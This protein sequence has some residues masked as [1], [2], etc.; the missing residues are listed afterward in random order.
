MRKLIAVKT[1]VVV[2][3]LVASV[4]AKLLCGVSSAAAATALSSLNLQAAFARASLAAVSSDM[5]PLNGQSNTLQFT[6]GG[7]VLGFQPTKAYLAS[8]DHA[9]SVEFLG[10]EGVMPEAAETVPAPGILSRSMPCTGVK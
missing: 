3:L 5:A 9:L 7:H 2:V 1:I 10:T 8:L 6:A 4:A